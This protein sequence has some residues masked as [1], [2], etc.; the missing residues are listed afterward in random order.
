M[1]LTLQFLGSA[2][3]RPEAGGGEAPGMPAKPKVQEAPVVDVE[4]DIPF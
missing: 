3:E 4:D 1:A 2:G